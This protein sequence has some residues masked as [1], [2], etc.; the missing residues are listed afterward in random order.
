[1]KFVWEIGALSILDLESKLPIVASLVDGLAEANLVFLNRKGLNGFELYKSGVKYQVMP[2]TWRDIPTCLMEGT[3]DCKSLVAWRLA[4]LRL[5]GEFAAVAHLVVQRRKK[6]AVFHVQ[7]KRASGA[8]EDPSER[9]GM[10][11]GDFGV[12]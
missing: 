6:H 7:I 5:K 8:I 10:K 2:S 4:E 3:A 11:S 9:C 1:M 12:W